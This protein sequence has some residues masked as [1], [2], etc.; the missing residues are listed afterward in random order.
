[1]P[2]PTAL[3]LVSAVCASCG[4]V[5]PSAQA[6]RSDPHGHLVW[7]ART[8]DVA[9]IRTLAARGVDL[10]A[11][12]VTGPR[13]VFPDLD[14]RDWTALQHAVHKRQTDAVRVLLEWGA[15]P[16]ATPP[17]SATTPLLIAA[18]NN[19][20]AMVRLLLDAG[21]DANWIRRASTQPEPGGALWHLL[22]HM[23]QR[24]QGVL[25]P[26]EALHLVSTISGEH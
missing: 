25:S 26:T 4:M 17:G 2:H 13:F 15:D 5:V 7:A 16:D 19:N 10:D 3:L 14:H 24:S 11:S 12:S 1:M 6:L 9:A 21:A 22:E 8:G 20:P 18:S 23:L